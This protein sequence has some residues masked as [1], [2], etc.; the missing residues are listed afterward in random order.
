VG[1]GD[2]G[3]VR[4]GDCCDH[5]CALDLPGALCPDGNT[6]TDDSC[7]GAGGCLSSPNT[8]PCE[9]GAFCTD[10]DACAGGACGPGLPRDCADA[11]PCTSDGC[12]ET[13]ARCVHTPGDDALC[14]DG[15]VC[16]TDRC[17]AGGCTSLPAS[18]APCDDGNVCTL[19][20]VR[21]AG[22]CAGGSEVLCAGCLACD[23]VAGCVL[24]QPRTGC[25]VPA[26]G[27]KSQLLLGDGPGDADNIGWQWRG[28]SGAFFGNPDETTYDLC[29]YDAQGGTPELVLQ[30]RPAQGV[31][32]DEPCWKASARGL[33]Y[34]NRAATPD[35]LT[36]ARLRAAPSAVPQ[37]RIQVK[38]RGPNLPP[39]ALPL[40]QDPAVVVQL[41][42]SDGM[43]WEATYGTARRN[44]AGKFKARS[45]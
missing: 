2:D 24:A 21:D 23:P 32:G 40:A 17:T 33:S 28:V 30:A 11:H 27:G 19:N 15:D 1:S 22:I 6:C 12:S 35:G 31:C 25:R 44:D 3:N 14:D 45:E 18:G 20:D 10:G 13:L 4:D 39:L 42:S 5:T 7:D 38:G 36:S 34:K 26:A 43:C 37:A 29:V 9:D 41:R 16:T 8:A